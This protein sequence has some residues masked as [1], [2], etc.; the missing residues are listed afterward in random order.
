MTNTKLILPLGVALAALL[1]NE[2]GASTISLNN[3]ASSLSGENLS[4]ESRSLTNQVLKELLYRI[5]TEQHFL[6]L[7]KSEGGVLYAQHRS[8]ASHYSHSS[9]M[10]HMSHRSGF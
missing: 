9:H 3:V 4:V 6:T 5:G 10:S 2:T 1:P 8:H 7:H